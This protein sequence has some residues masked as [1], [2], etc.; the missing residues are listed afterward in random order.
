MCVPSLAVI[1]LSVYQMTHISSPKRVGF[2]PDTIYISNISTKKLIDKGVANHAS[3][4][5]EFSHFFH[6]QIHYKPYNQL[7]WKLNILYL[8]HFLMTMFLVIIQIQNLNTRT[9]LNQ[10]LILKMK[11][12]KI[13]IQIQFLV[14]F[15]GLNK[16]IKSL[17]LM[18]TC[19]GIHL[20][21][22]EPNLSFKMRTL[23]FFIQT[24]FLQRDDILSQRGAT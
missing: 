19:P 12:L 23:C 5:Y 11:F 10:I 18:G 6:T 16:V 2:V 9:K 21:E 1:L 14:P 3:K 15:L 24:H 17:K 20:R 7:K 13:Q 22:E 8:N 4:E